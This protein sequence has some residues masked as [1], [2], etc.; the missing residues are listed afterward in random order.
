MGAKAGETIEIPELRLDQ[1]TKVLARPEGL[2][3]GHEHELARCHRA[4]ARE[5]FWP[6]EPQ[7]ALVAVAE[8]ENEPG[9]SSGD[10]PAEHAIR[11]FYGVRLLLDD[12]AKTGAIL[13][14][15]LGFAE[16]G[17][18]GSVDAWCRTAGTGLARVTWQSRGHC[19]I[20]PWQDW[21][22][23]TTWDGA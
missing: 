14:D 7:D 20:P 3:V 4:Q 22:P 15:V 2:V 16:A 1:V 17:R 13:T 10:I 19:A 9:W 6:Q 5:Q 23:A 11:G 12:A 21:L 8:A 18:E